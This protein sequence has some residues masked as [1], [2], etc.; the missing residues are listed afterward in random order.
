MLLRQLAAT[1]CRSRC[2]T[3][4]AILL[5]ERARPAPTSA[6]SPSPTARSRPRARSCVGSGTTS[7]GSISGFV[8]SPLQSGHMPSGE[9]NE[10]LCGESSGKPR[11]QWW[12]AELLGVERAPRRRRSAISSRPCPS[13]S[14]VSTES[15]RRG[16]S[17]LPASGTA[18]RS[19]TTSIVC[20][21]F[22]SSAGSSSP[23]HDLA[24]DAQAREALAD[25]LAQQLPV[26]ALAVV[27]EP[28]EQQEARA[29]RQRRA[30]GRRSPR[31]RAARP[32]RPQHV[33]VLAADARPEH[34]QVVV[35]LG[36]RAD[37][38]A[39]V[40][41]RGLLLDRDRRREPADVVVLRLLHLPEELAR[42]GRERLD[43][44]AL[45]LGVER[46]ERERR[47]ARARRPREDDERVLR[48]A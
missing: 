45:A 6:P 36:D 30:A 34:A 39:R 4:S 3:P 24:V 10:K 13:R 20:L 25:R 43:V 7:A 48:E 38:R 28:R 41:A 12:H 21:R 16:R 1:A 18:S 2:R 47:L 35:D 27:D 33:A 46:V 37:R 11:S 17:S 14:A 22:L 32:A 15:V 9:L 5:S 23:A 26:L 31:P 29:R 40:V 44:A 19:T 8:P 42:V